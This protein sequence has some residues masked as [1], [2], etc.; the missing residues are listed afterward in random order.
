M[1][2]IGANVFPGSMAG[3][4]RTGFTTGFTTGLQAIGL[5]GGISD[6]IA[7]FAAADFLEDGA[8]AFIAAWGFPASCMKVTDFGF[9]NDLQAIGLHGG[10]SN[11]GSC[12][13]PFA[14]ADFLEDGAAGFVEA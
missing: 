2:I 10:N 1:V 8:A 14:A 7:G 5:R 4:G 12:I 3:I 11:G 13:P 6:I 9:T